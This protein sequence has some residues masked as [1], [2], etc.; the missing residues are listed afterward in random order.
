[1]IL[2]II[3]ISRG[4]PEEV[5]QTPSGAQCKRLDPDKQGW[6]SN[7]SGKLYRFRIIPSTLELPICKLPQKTKRTDYCNQSVAA[8]H[9]TIIQLY[10]LAHTP[11]CGIVELQQA[12]HRTQGN[13]VPDLVLKKA[14]D[15]WRTRYSR[16]SRYPIQNRKQ[17]CVHLAKIFLLYSGATT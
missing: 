15:H 16:C 12:N 5:Q 6:M 8:R 17:K 14:P 13:Q 1:M 3:W 7:K 2:H 11:K 4:G 10:F 9:L